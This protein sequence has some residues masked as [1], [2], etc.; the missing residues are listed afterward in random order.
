MKLNG[1]KIYLQPVSLKYVDVYRKW[2]HDKDVIRYTTINPPTREEQI[3][4]IKERET[5]GVEEVFSIFLKKDDTIIGN[6]GCHNL[7]NPDNNFVLGIIIGEK[8]YWGEGYGTDAFKTVIR[9]MFEEKDANMV[10]LD[11]FVGNKSA[12]RVYEKCG[13][14]EIKKI[15]KT[16]EREKKEV[17]CILMQV[18]REEYENLDYAAPFE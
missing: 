11:V 9:Y 1:N 6:V 2:V 7:D 5:S 18:T 3:K 17:E 13:M 4:W 12:Q 16:N 10:S 15:T 14:K 8:E